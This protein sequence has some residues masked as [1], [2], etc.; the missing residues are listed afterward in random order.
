[1]II[2]LYGLPGSGKTTFARKAAV[3]NEWTR[4][5]LIK[6]IEI[7][8][9]FIIGFMLHPVIYTRGSIYY[10]IRNKSMFY[11]WNF[12]V[13]RYAKYQK[14]R[15]LSNAYKYV[16]LDEGPLQNIISYHNQVINSTDLV[17]QINLS[18]KA[19]KVIIFDINEEI[20]KKQLNNKVHESWRKNNENF[21]ME[22]NF[23]LFKNNIKNNSRYHVWLGDISYGELKANISK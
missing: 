22:Q 11:I 9:Y 12:F 13:V 18:P 19:D 17:E 1:M 2:E 23:N 8:K 16:L 7:I 14:A 6:K 4:V 15:S 3:S 21:I 5:I 10:G 20:R